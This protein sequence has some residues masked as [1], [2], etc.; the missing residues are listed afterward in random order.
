MNLLRTMLTVLIIA[1]G[2]TALVGMLTAVDGMKSALYSS[3]AQMGSN[4]FTIK[5]ESDLV[6]FGMRGM[7]VKE[8]KAIDFNQ[9]QFF[10]SRFDFPANVSAYYTASDQ[11]IVQYR[12]TKTA[13]KIQVKGTDHNYMAISGLELEEG[14]SFTASEEQHGQKVAILGNTLKNDLFGAQ[15]CLG[16]SIVIGS[17]KFNIIGYLKPKGS[18]FGQ[19]EDNLVIAPIIAT[20]SS[21]PS[22]NESYEIAV[23]VKNINVIDN[24]MDESTGLFRTLRKVKLG[25]DN[26]FSV[27]KSEEMANIL[28]GNISKITIIAFV[29]GIITLIGAAVGLTNIMIV[30]VT[31]RTR[32]IG[33]RKAIG[34]NNKNIRNQFLSE[35]IVITQIGGLVGATSGILLGNLV[36]SYFNQPFF[37]PWVW[38]IVSIIIC[39]VVGVGAGMYPALKASRLDPIESLRYE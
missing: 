9:V 20:Q 12:S 8:N 21:F 35:A 6:R 25:D 33:V 11:A 30:S 23:Q 36:A 18:A 15:D 39:F 32:E 27:T 4:T 38:L 13:P 22:S 17:Q 28:L 26:D 3:F 31:E 5:N 37:I 1:F 2:I 34:A 7:K 19:S 14:R 10:K 24:A 29:I 16:E